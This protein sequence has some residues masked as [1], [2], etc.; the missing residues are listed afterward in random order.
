M[1]MY[2]NA[3]RTK[4]KCYL[5][6][7]PQSPTESQNPPLLRS[8]VGAQ[9]DGWMGDKRALFICSVHPH[10]TEH[11]PHCYILVCQVAVV[12]GTEDRANVVSL[13]SLLQSQRVPPFIMEY[14][15]ETS[16]PFTSRRLR[17]DCYSGGGN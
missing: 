13:I 8:N 9:E 11:A 3:Y 7:P 6:L 2:K 15:I 1:V 16:G 10:A 4:A 12:S 14:R 17:L 5:I